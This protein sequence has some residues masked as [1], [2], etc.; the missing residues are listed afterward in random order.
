VVLGQA[1]AWLKVRTEET[2]WCAT[3]FLSIADRGGENWATVTA[4][5]LNYRHAPEG[6]KIGAFS[7]GDSY[8]VAGTQG[9]WTKIYLIGWVHGDFVEYA[10]A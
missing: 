10:N 4:S 8:P 7:R 2:A 3:R 6:I 5:L 9:D 1:G